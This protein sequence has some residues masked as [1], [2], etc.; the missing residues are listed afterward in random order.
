MLGGQPLRCRGWEG[1]LP[2][3]WVGEALGLGGR[4]GFE[5]V[6]AGLGAREGV[7]DEAAVVF[8]EREE[9]ASSVWGSAMPVR[10]SL[11]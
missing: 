4:G 10:M 5:E 2:Y 11:V 3:G 8:A 1:A 9:I 7:G 6:V